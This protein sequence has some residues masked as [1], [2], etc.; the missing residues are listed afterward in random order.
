MLHDV[1]PSFIRIRGSADATSK[2][3]HSVQYVFNGQPIFGRLKLHGGHAIT[4]ATLIDVFAD[5]EEDDTVTALRD[6]ETFA[7]DDVS[8]GAVPIVTGK[9]DQNVAVRG[10]TGTTEIG[11]D[12][13]DQPHTIDL[14]RQ[15][16]FDVLHDEGDRL[17]Q[18]HDPDVLA[19]QKMPVIG[20][21]VVIAD[22]FVPGSTDKR[23]RL[24]GWSSD[25]DRRLLTSVGHRKF[26][27]QIDGQ[28]FDTASHKGFAQP[29]ACEVCPETA[30]EFLMPLKR[31]GWHC[32]WMC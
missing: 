25:K 5:A 21:G 27:K 19:I 11:H 28:R 10:P 23:I 6:S 16:P 7:A 3:G 14:R 18:A 15:H 1:A 26:G 22:P 9:G 29:P 31:C 13:I 2:P 20:G 8:R 17:S 12:L 24:T 32:L 30:A 4:F